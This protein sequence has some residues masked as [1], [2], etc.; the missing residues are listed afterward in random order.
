M[1]PP[2]KELASGPGWRVLDIACS[3][4]PADRRVEELY[5]VVNIALVTH[6][7]FQYRS[8]QGEASLAPGGVV[9]GNHGA[10]FEC[11][12]EHGVGDRCLAF[13]YAPE[14]F[15][16]IVAA[17][18]GVASI[19][20]KPAS[21]PPL[22]AM[23][24]LFA[25]AEAARDDADAAA[26]E[27]LAL[28]IAARVATLAADATGAAPASV[29]D[30]R[31]IA[32]AIRRLES[33]PEESVG[34]A[35]LATEIGMSR[36]HFLRVFREVAGVTPHQYVLRRRLHR[37]ALRLRRTDAPVAAIAFEAGFNDLSTFNR[38]FRRVMGASP[39]AWRARR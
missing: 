37:A 39:G 12:H 18:P 21:L 14:I 16:S 38:R 30:Q 35:A 24:P 29:R 11:G 13:H 8:V 34:L 23:T 7:A 31:R 33:A 2:R 4:G 3:A 17:T 5:D 26:L 36:Y 20:F 32:E 6:G 25:A 19:S 15:E 27:E 22:E 1:I 28:E 9:L 10:C